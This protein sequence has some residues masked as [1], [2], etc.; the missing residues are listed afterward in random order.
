MTTPPEKL[1]SSN[2]RFTPWP[3]LHFIL[4]V[5]M[6]GSISLALLPYISPFG[7]LPVA[8]AVGFVFSKLAD[9]VTSPYKSISIKKRISVTILLLFIFSLSGSLSYATIYSLLFAKQNGLRYLELQ[10][11]K[12]R[13]DIQSAKT[14][15]SNFGHNLV[16]IEQHSK[17]MATKEETSGGSCPNFIASGKRQGRI[18]KFRYDDEIATA[19]LNNTFQKTTQ[20]FSDSYASVIEKL[21]KPESYE[22]AVD[23]IIL[24]NALIREFN[25]V[26]GSTEITALLDQLRS[27]KDAPI[28]GSTN[29]RCGDNIRDGVLNTAIS[30][31]KSLTQLVQLPEIR[32]AI[33]LNSPH[34]ITNRSLLRGM[35]LVSKIPPI[36]F[37]S[38]FTGINTTFPDDPLM[39]A[40]LDSK[41]SLNFETLPLFISA[42]LELMIIITARLAYKNKTA[43]FDTVSIQNITVAKNIT[44]AKGVVLRGILNLVFTVHDEDFYQLHDENRRKNLKPFTHK[45]TDPQFEPREKEFSINLLKWVVD[46]DWG[47]YLIIPD[48][49][50]HEL[51]SHAAGILVYEKLAEIIGYSISWN[52]LSGIHFSL[53]RRAK[54]MRF[55]KNHETHNYHIF[56]L[57]NHFAQALRLELLKQSHKSNIQSTK[58]PALTSPSFI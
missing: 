30:S 22:K 3:V 50:N 26:R 43:P 33:D 57:S 8:I 56:K 42:L 7:A 12:S 2:I 48:L 11:S 35:T 51:D 39:K 19:L 21:T 4:V 53:D 24:L 29:E 44:G 17:S 25:A 41:G 36:S 37:L 54:D 18:Y 15:I 47:T 1:A 49:T 58:P 52:D 46:F 27:L 23:Q 13:Y 14:A 20:S 6:I 31:L 40:E 5:V 32:P 45:P 34:E 28:P 9:I 16:A 38:S 10:I 55:G